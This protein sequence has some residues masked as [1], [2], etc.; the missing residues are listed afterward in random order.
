MTVFIQVSSHFPLVRQKKELDQTWSG[1]MQP[2]YSLE[3]YLY[4]TTNYPEDTAADHNDQIYFQYIL[5]F[6]CLISLLLTA[7]VLFSVFVY[8]L[9]VSLTQ[10]L[11]MCVS[12]CRRVLLCLFRK[13]PMS[14]STGWRVK[15]CPPST[16]SPGS[17][18]SMATAWYPCSWR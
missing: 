5:F 16:A 17:P 7:G 4:T 15:V 2:N 18:V 9:L 8:F 10:F 13:P 11:G 12:P 14:C 6:P 1:I 3:Y